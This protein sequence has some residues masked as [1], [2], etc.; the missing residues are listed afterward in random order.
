M[1][2]DHTIPKGGRPG[3]HLKK[4]ENPS[5]LQM[6]ARGPKPKQTPAFPVPVFAQRRHKCYVHVPVVVDRV[7]SV[8][9]AGVIK[10]NTPSRVDSHPREA[11][12]ALSEKKQRGGEHLLSGQGTLHT[13]RTQRA[14]TTVLD[15]QHRDQSDTVRASIGGTVPEGGP[16][17]TINK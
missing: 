15:Y 4:C 14:R 13:T 11:R 17:L 3:L 7:L 10:Y 16:G 8:T 6:G 9:V 12:H 2:P 1:A 5:H